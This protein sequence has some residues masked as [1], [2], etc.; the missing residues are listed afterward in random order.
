MRLF[1]QTEPGDWN[2]VIAGVT[3]ALQN[4]LHKHTDHEELP[5]QHPLQVAESDLMAKLNKERQLLTEKFKTQ[6]R[7]LSSLNISPDDPEFI[8][9]LRKLYLISELHNEVGEKISALETV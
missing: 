3:V 4:L 8:K 2:S 7:H 9:Q 5:Q 1:R 6:A